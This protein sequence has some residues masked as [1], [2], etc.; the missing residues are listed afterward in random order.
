MCAH[1]LLW[2]LHNYSSLLNNHRQNNVGSHQKKIPHIQGQR[3]SPSKTVGGA[4]SCLDSNH[5]P[6]GNTWRAHTKFCVHQDPETPQRLSQT[7]LWVFECPLRRFRSAAACHRG[8]G[9]GCSRPGHTAWGISPIGRS[10]LTTPQSHRADN[11]QTAGELYQINSRTVAKVKTGFF[12][13]PDFLFVEYRFHWASLNFPEFQRVNSNNSWSGKGGGAEMD[14][15]KRWYSIE[16][17]PSFLLKE[18][19][20]QYLWVLLQNWGSHPRGGG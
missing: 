17:R 15:I 9:S 5:I 19:G 16:A 1:L 8:M 12:C 3:R 11:P 2:E 13:V 18:Y 4:E 10:P 14:A 6:S 20:Q 7:C